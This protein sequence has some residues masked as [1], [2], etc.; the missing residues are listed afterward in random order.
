MLDIDRLW[1]RLIRFKNERGWYNY[2]I[3]RSAILDLLE[4]ADW[5]DLFVPADYLKVSR[6]ENVAVWQEIA[7]NLL[8]KFA[9]RRYE[10]D[11]REWEAKHLEYAGLASGD[12]NLPKPD[13]ASPDAKGYYS[14][15][16]DP[17]ETQL[18]S[19]L[20]AFA[21]RFRNHGSGALPVSL[22]GIHAGFAAFAFDRHLYMPLLWSDGGSS[23]RIQPFA[24]ND[25]E[26]R[27]VEDLRSYYDNNPEFFHDVKL[28]LLRNHSRG[29][30]TGFFEASGFYPDFILWLLK[31]DRQH[32]VFVDPK[33]IRLLGARDPKIEFY[34]GIKDTAK[35]LAAQTID[36]HSFII[37]NSPAAIMQGQW[38][39]TKSEMREQNILFA[40]DDRDT[41]I[42]DMLHSVIAET[43][44]N[45]E[46]VVMARHIKD[47]WSFSAVTLEQEVQRAFSALE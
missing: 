1:F 47:L 46:I 45:K 11:R 2:N 32:I 29:R 25:G 18:I 38:N 4:A 8:L 10:H 36:L 12:P 26:K 15:S 9:Q 28:F 31:G 37:S 39:T 27:F 20:R 30:G 44:A 16:V 6:F 43:T 42:G 41:Y 13:P 14:V 24:L 23:I 35:L 7:E 34:K 3:P 21:E 33:G 40:V 17:S 5:Y 19:Q 22:T